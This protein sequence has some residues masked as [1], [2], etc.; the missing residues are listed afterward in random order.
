MTGSFYGLASDDGEG[1][2]RGVEVS[3]MKGRMV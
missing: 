2:C 1:G 3:G